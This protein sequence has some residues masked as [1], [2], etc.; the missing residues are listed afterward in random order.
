MSIH[1]QEVDLSKPQEV[2]F[3]G[4]RYFNIVLNL[5][6][7]EFFWISQ[8]I[9]ACLYPAQTMLKAWQK[10][11]SLTMKAGVQNTMLS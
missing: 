7:S 5:I 10:N 8:E 3:F 1:Y 2:L 4:K 6:V 9:K 11:K